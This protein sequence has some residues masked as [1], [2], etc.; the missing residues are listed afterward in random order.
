MEN[1]CI[2]KKKS[3]LQ[4]SPQSY[5]KDYGDF[6][7]RQ[8]AGEILS[9]T[10]KKTSFGCLLW[11]RVVRL[12]WLKREPL[13]LIKKEPGTQYASRLSLLAE[14]EGFEPSVPL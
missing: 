11:G 13:I 7:V 4:K 9:K 6:C 2:L 14:R 5:Q 1:R 3:L 12:D 8:K 10:K